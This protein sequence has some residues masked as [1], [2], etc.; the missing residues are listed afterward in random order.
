M[1]NKRSLAPNESM[2]LHELLTLKNL[3][4]TKSITML[5]LISDTELKIILENDII[6][7]EQ[8]IKELKSVLEQSRV[9]TPITM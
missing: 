4:L 6:K 9:A 3:T 8:H 2:Q 1:E 7:T 5:P